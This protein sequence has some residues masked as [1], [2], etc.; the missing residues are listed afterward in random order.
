MQ[1]ECRINEKLNVR[2]VQREQL[3]SI[4]SCAMIIA[5]IYFSKQWLNER[6]PFVHPPLVSRSHWGEAP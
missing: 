5:K 2:K 3:N 6:T 1:I 4:F